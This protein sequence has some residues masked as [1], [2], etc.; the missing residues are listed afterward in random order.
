MHNES[1]ADREPEASANESEPI[2]PSKLKRIK[3][4]L[5]VAGMYIIPAAVIGGSMYLGV[6]TTKMQLET[7]KL[8][9]ET[10][11]LQKL[12]DAAIQQ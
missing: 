4:N 12:A 1:R 3:S 9:F 8:N 7:A 2:K 10:A 5:T 6:K 11:K